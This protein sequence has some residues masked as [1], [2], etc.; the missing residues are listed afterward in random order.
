MLII[1]YIYSQKQQSCY[2]FETQLQAIKTILNK[3][4]NTSR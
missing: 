2:K 1:S 3:H 4:E